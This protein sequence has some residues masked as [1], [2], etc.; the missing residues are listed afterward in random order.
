[1]SIDDLRTGWEQIDDDECRRASGTVE[2]IGRRWSSAIMLGIAR[3]ATRFGEILATV[4][5]LSDRMLAL[6]MRE[7]EHTGLVDRIV[8]PTT[9]VTVRYVLTARG[10]DLLSALQPLVR[11]GQRWEAAESKHD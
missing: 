6:R 5:G 1:M 3:G 8:E 11:Y 4:A 10:R 7:L 9:P 2:L